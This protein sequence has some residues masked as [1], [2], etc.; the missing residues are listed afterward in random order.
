MATPT[1]SDPRPRS[2]GGA[3]FNHG[4]SISGYEH[5][6]IDVLNVAIFLLA[7]VAAIL[8]AT[9]LAETTEGFQANVVDLVGIS[10]EAALNLLYGLFVTVGAILSLL[11]LAV[12]LATR[13]FRL[14]FYVVGA[15]IGV[16]VAMALIES[17]AA[18]GTTE[19]FTNPYALAAGIPDE[20]PDSLLV[21]ECA[22]A[23]TVLSPWV[24]RGWRR[25]LW[26]VLGAV[27]VLQLMVMV[28]PPPSTL[29]ALAIGPLFGS[30][31]LLAFGRPITRPT[32]DSIVQ[33]LSAY[34][35]A[36]TS[37][38]RADVDARG[39]T[40]WIAGLAD[41]DKLFVKVLGAD[42]RAADRLFRTYRRF[43]LKN[44]GDQPAERSLRRTV[45]H[46]ALVALAA[47][48]R[49]VRTPR[50][51]TV[52]EIGDDSF[53][54]A[55]E[56][57]PGRSLD[58]VADTDVTDDVLRDL[59]E[60]VGVL[61]R[62]RIAHRDLRL[63]NVFLSGDGLVQMID[64]GFSEVAA[65]EELLNADMAQILASAALKVGPQRAVDTA[66][67]VLGEPA[68]AAALPRLQLV[69]LSG[70]TQSELRKVPELLSELRETV[71]QRCA[72]EQF[73]LAPI[74]RFHIGAAGLLAA[75]FALTW[76][77]LPVMVGLDEVTD[78]FQGAAWGNVVPLALC[79]LVA[80]FGSAIAFVAASRRHLARFP[81]FAL[82]FAE[83]YAGTADS[84]VLGKERIQMRFLTRHGLSEAEAGRATA[85][86]ALG[87]AVLHG[88][89]AVV[90]VAIVL[91]RS[92]LHGN[93]EAELI[94][95]LLGTIAVVTLG[96]L[97]IP[98]VRRAVL[99]RTSEIRGNP[100]GLIQRISRSP[101]ATIRVLV[102]SAGDIL[103]GVFAFQ[104]ATDVFGLGPGLAV[105][106]SVQLLGTAVATLVPT[107]GH[108]IAN[109]AC[110]LVGLVAVG[111]GAGP[112]VA[113][114][115]VYRL[116]SFWV[117]LA[118]G[119]GSYNWL[120]HNQHV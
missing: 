58:A 85:T 86:S 7:S 88:T 84:A 6:P 1:R 90:F 103:L 36:A 14:F 65:S 111:V 23:I 10:S 41:G 112:A 107:P 75:A 100:L 73:D 105:M 63:A 79:T 104:F 95:I 49:G 97:L 91:G 89:L 54:L 42:E 93:F 98:A 56:L 116:V 69:A 92:L 66:V 45:E 4:R 29:T 109:E 31:V 12:P 76:I 46:E 18:R 70:A 50:L 57:L 52:G 108:S 20:G 37:L 82:Q 106:G 22:A 118:L 13:R 21:A 119:W 39:S 114:V 61:R 2:A 83:L 19:M 32:E 81:V 30:A 115:L 9:V 16:G 24:T 51:A 27:V 17:L 38:V 71:T 59:W 96:A 33:A 43:R 68:C 15:F 78:A 113:T 99:T 67:E 55:Y 62:I 87:R 8:L 40:P 5:S 3:F 110:L 53:F 120:R 28:H 72:V 60:Q 77:A 34:G 35:F 47:R 102:G 101:G 94:L 74:S 26:W 11:I 48:D 80:L 44:V 25:T 117:V 64:F